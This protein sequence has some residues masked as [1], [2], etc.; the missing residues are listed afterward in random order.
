MDKDGIFNLSGDVQ[1]GD[2]HYDGR[3]DADK[4]LELVFGS[5]YHIA[6]GEMTPGTY[7]FVYNGKLKR[8]DGSVMEPDVTVQA[9][10]GS[11]TASITQ[12]VYFYRK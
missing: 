1:W 3:F 7:L 8:E 11:D 12:N 2:F 10:F 9:T 4:H 6:K 5:G